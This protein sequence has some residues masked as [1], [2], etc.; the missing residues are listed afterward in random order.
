LILREELIRRDPNNSSWRANLA[1]EYMLIGPALL[2]QNKGEEAAAGYRKA[3]DIYASLA[4]SD[5]DQVSWEQSAM[6]AFSRLADVLDTIPE[7]SKEAIATLQESVALQKELVAARPGLQPR[8]ANLAITYVDLGSFLA[9]AKRLDDAV[10]AYEESVTLLE[11]L[12]EEAPE[13]LKRRLVL[14]ISYARLGELRR[15]AHDRAG[16][17]DFYKKALALRE[18]LARAQP[19]DPDAQ[20]ALSRALVNLADVDDEPEDRYL[21]ALQILDTL[22]RNGT[23]PA[24]STK[25][26]EKLRTS[27]SGYYA[28]EGRSAFYAGDFQRAVRSLATALKANPADHLLVV[29]LHLA[30][31]RSGVEDGMEFQANASY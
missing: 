11:K 5:V 26:P 31:L 2:K 13:N 3:A 10:I 14:S 7:K 18:E 1:G 15:Y 9:A 29:W 4:K 28:Q 20:F 16:A 21:R 8:R 17:V 12:I 27:V 30:R 19:K 24:A 22:A 23:L 25:A 6:M